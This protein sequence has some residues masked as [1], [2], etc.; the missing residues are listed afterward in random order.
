MNS[1]F[2]PHPLSLSVCVCVYTSIG[3]LCGGILLQGRPAKSST[4][5]P[6]SHVGT[7]FWETRTSHVFRVLLCTKWKWMMKLVLC[8]WSAKRQLD[9]LG[10]L[11]RMTRVATEIAKFQVA[12][13]IA[14]FHFPSC[15]YGACFCVSIVRMLLVPIAPHSTCSVG[16]LQAHVTCARPKSVALGFPFSNQLLLCY[17]MPSPLKRTTTPGLLT[18]PPLC[19]SGWM[20]LSSKGVRKHTCN[21]WLSKVGL[22]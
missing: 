12:T 6:E 20:Q 1:I 10:G 2:L 11:V 19:E 16:Q 5:G 14:K 9:A 3:M 4:P 22:T 15:L 8:C 21:T 13:K 17:L 7:I 18:L